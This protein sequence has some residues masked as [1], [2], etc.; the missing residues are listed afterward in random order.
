M[1]TRA[2]ASICCWPPERLRAS[3]LLALGEL[4]EEL[5]HLVDAAV[6]LARACRR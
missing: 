5:E 6:D 3:C 1:S 4:G 2:S